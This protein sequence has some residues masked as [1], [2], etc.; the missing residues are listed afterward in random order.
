MGA[1]RIATASEQQAAAITFALV[2]PYSRQK[3]AAIAYLEA[4]ISKPETTMVTPAF[5][6]KGMENYAQQYDIS[7]PAFQ[8]L[9]HIYE[10]LGVYYGHLM[11]ETDSSHILEYQQG[12]ISFDQAIE[13][14]QSIAEAELYE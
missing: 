9:Y 6:K 1:P 12:L 13:R 4:V 5:F 8:D 14:V 2:N 3:D 11:V 10:T 7:L